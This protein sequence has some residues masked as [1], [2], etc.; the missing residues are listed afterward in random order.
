MLT[1][2]F[3][4]LSYLQHTLDIILH[5]NFCFAILY[6]KEPERGGLLGLLKC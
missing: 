1:D 6:I 5:S 4:Y 3:C 2:K